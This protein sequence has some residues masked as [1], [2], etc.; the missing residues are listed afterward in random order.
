MYKQI[1]MN[2]ILKTGKR[3]QVMELTGRSPL[4]RQ[5]SASDSSA[6]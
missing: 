1:L 5:M 2:G 6:I 4:R 3:G